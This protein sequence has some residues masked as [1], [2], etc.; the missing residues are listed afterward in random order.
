ML[1]EKPF[2]AMDLALMEQLHSN[3]ESCRRGIKENMSV[4]FFRYGCDCITKVYE[5][6]IGKCVYK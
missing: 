3:I 6:K 4:D 5:L 2:F 1:S